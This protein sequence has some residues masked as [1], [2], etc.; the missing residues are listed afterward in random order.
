MARVVRIGLLGC[1]VVGGG[2][3]AALEQNRAALLARAGAEV[4]VHRI[5]V[6]DLAKERHEAVDAAR[7]C[8]DWRSVVNDPAVDVV[9]EVM[10]GLEP[11]HAAIQAALAAGKDVVTANKELLARHGEALQALA[12]AKGRALMC[13]GSVLGG[14]PAVHNLHS[15]FVANRIGHIRGIVNGT[16][17]Y[18]L[19]RMEDAGLDF[20]EALAE[21]QRLGY[22]EADP[23][24]DL[25]GRDALYKFQILAR[26]AFDVD[27]VADDVDVAGISDVTQ[28]DVQLAA[29]LGCRLRH[30]VEGRWD[31]ESGRLWASVR[32][33]LTTQDDPLYHV[34]GADNFLGLEGDLVGRIG[35]LGPGAGA[36][37]TASAVVEDIVQ[38]LQGG[39]VRLRALRRASV[40]AVR[41]PAFLVRRRFPFGVAAGPEAALAWRSIL[42]ATQVKYAGMA[43]GDAEAWWIRGCDAPAAAVLSAVSSDLA[44][45]FAVYP[46]ANLPG[47]RRVAADFRT[48]TAAVV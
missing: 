23:A 46:A 26:L 31:A 22:A 2:V 8:T 35:L 25:E 12:A 17:N 43:G 32:P 28:A 1:G 48:H 6:R 45:E 13:E 47:G 36:L 10:G 30:V 7:L 11:A 38:L 9:V 4:V 37:P 27:V 44:G 19:S 5:A 21:A 15:Y 20:A 34:T 24:M 14:V 33:Q 41:Y 42:G 18:I 16:N 39:S 40:A 29:Q 3:V